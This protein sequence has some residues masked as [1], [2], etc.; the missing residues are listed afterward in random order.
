L[1]AN[2][3]VSKG[4]LRLFFFGKKFKFVS[5][6]SRDFRWEKMGALW[7]PFGVVGFLLPPLRYLAPSGWAGRH[8]A[9][10]LFF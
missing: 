6:F 2:P 9:V 8:P 10:Y 1:R 4:L 7:L 3:F 5:G